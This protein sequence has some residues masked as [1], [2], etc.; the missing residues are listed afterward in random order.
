[1][2]ST[3]ETPAQ[4]RRCKRHSLRTPASRAAGIGPRCAAI[5]AAFQGLGDRQ[6]DKAR[7]LIADKGVVP[8]CH[9]GVYRVSSSKGDAEYRTAVTGQCSCTW[10]LRRVSAEA[11]TCFHVGAVR[12]YHSPRR[13]LRRSDFG[14]AA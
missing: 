6:Q 13:V 9:E 14:K 7:E 10:G 5:E 1:M 12:L 3:T 4:C 8:T 11:K 2:S